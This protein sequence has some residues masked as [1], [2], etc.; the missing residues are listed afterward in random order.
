MSI[1]DRELQNPPLELD[2]YSADLREALGIEADELII[3]QPTRVVQRK[4][5]EH[6]IELVSL[7]GRKAHLVISHH[8]VTTV[9]TTRPGW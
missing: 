1:S 9:M 6:A 2:E 7:L 8:L 3:L 4:G 5:I